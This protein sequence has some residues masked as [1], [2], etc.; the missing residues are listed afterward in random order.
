MSYRN[1][2]GMDN[3]SYKIDEGFCLI[4]LQQIS[5]KYFR[6]KGSKGY[7]THKGFFPFQNVN[8]SSNYRKL[9]K[10]HVGSLILFIKFSKMILEE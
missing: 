5:Y 8:Y 2:R 1:Y 9:K 3:K 6:E 7:E 10:C 4:K